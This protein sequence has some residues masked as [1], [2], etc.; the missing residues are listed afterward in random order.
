MCN[1]IEWS[2]ILREM[3]RVSGIRQ[4]S[5]GKISEKVKRLGKMVYN[6]IL[7]RNIGMCL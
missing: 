4:E 7:Q 1:M 6:C 5:Q 3:L 2:K